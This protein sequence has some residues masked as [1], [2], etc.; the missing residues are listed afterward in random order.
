M[1]K[2]RRNNGKNRYNR[3]SVK[4]IVCVNCGRRCPKDKSVKRFTIRDIVDQSSKKDLE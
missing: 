4:P 2:K 1:P 3:G